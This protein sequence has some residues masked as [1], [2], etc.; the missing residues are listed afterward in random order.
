MDSW[1][2]TLGECQRY[3]ALTAPHVVSTVG[4]EPQPTGHAPINPHSGLGGEYGAQ[5]EFA[6]SVKSWFPGSQKSGSSEML[7]FTPYWLAM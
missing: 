3:S 1:T 4:V 7:P 5:G 6:C 2:R